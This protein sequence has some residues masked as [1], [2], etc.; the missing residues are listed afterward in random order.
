MIETKRNHTLRKNI[1]RNYNDN[2][3]AEF[4][5]RIYEHGKSC[6]NSEN[7]QF[8]NFKMCKGREYIKNWIDKEIGSGKDSFDN[9]NEFPIL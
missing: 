9:F 1:I 3:L 5:Y 4:L 7:C 6:H 8:C 2:D